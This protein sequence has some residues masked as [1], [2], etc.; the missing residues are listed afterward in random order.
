ML[1][2]VRAILIVLLNLIFYGLVVF[3]GVKL[4]QVSYS[5]AY[6]ILGDMAMEMPPGQDKFFTITES[7]DEFAVANNLEEMELVKNK[8]SFFYPPYFLFYESSN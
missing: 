6:E 2:T 7:Q 5:F 4:C 8:Y 3:G 1:K